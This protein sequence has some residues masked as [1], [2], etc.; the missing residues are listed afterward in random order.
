MVAALQEQSVCDTIRY[1]LQWFNGLNKTIMEMHNG[2]H[3]PSTDPI[4]QVKY[5]ADE[6]QRDPTFQQ[7][8][9]KILPQNYL[10]WVT[11]P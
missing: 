10:F 6:R 8:V 11:R 3:S 9:L 5:P 4:A 2:S 7:T 1:Q